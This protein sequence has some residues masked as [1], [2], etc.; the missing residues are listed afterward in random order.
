MGRGQRNCS[1]RQATPR[2]PARSRSLTA[3]SPY[4]RFFGLLPLRRGNFEA[5]SGFNWS[6]P[7][8]SICAPGHAR[9]LKLWWDHNSVTE[10]GYVF[11][12]HRQQPLG[13]REIFPKP[14]LSRDCCTI[15]HRFARGT[16]WHRES[17]ARCCG[18][19][20]GAGNAS[21]S[22]IPAEVNSASM[23]LISARSS[24]AVVGNASRSRMPA[25]DS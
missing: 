18:Q 25:S 20:L 3:A 23:R 6:S 19:H 11:D 24:S 15:W 13:G 21:K 8:L 7:N 22:N 9:V 17:K 1:G 4:R 16:N 2:A 14:H 12:H 5:A 10:G